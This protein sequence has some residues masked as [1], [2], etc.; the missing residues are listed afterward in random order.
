M[1]IFKRVVQRV[2]VIYDK[3]NQI[4]FWYQQYQCPCS[5]TETLPH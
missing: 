2:M 3:R 5:Y 4:L 1:Q